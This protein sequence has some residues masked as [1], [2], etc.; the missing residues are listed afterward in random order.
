MIQE[1]DVKSPIHYFNSLLRDHD[2]QIPVNLDPN[3][4]RRTIA[5]LE[6][7]RNH[8]EKLSL[9]GPNADW[10]DVRHAWMD[11]RNMVDSI[12]NQADDHLTTIEN[13]VL[14]F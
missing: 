4:V 11:I 3:D 14:E 13:E 9:S 2:G 12:K 6:T 1:S 8:W 7:I 5:A 10:V